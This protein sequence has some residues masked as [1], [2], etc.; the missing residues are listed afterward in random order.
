MCRQQV[1]RRN[2]HPHCL[3]L[4]ALQHAGTR[5]SMP[6][7]AQQSCFFDSCEVNCIRLASATLRPSKQLP[8]GAQLAECVQT[9]TS[10]WHNM[11]TAAWGQGLV[12]VIN[13][14]SKLPFLNHKSEA[15]LNLE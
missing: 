3:L 2:P 5:P 12:C 10:R 13:L 11:T 1:L 9:R 6:S 15:V 8:I 4:P 14:H 7:T